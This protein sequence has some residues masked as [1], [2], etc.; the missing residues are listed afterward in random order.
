MSGQ[1]Y[2]DVYLVLVTFLTIFAVSQYNFN[3][4]SNINRTIVS[5][6]LFALAITVVLVLIIGF[7]PLHIAFIDMLNYNA[8]YNHLFGADFEFSFDVDNL[9]FD[10]WFAYMASAG[11][12]IQFFFLICAFVYF[13]S[14]YVA[15]AKL[16][17]RDTLLAL[18]VYLAAFSTFSY[19]TNGIKAGMAAAL[20]LVALAYS[21]KKL[22]SAL[23]A[24]ITLGI[25]HSMLLVIVAYFIV[26]LIRNP[27]WYFVLWCIA[28][29][30]AALHITYF[31]FLFAG[32]TDEHGA[33]YLLS[34]ENS[35]FR[36]DFI[37]YSAVP[38]I[39]G[40]VL[41]YKYRIKSNTYNL[42]LSVYMLSNSVWM[43]CM[44]SNFTNR[45]SYLS[46][47][48]YPFVLLYPFVNILWSR[49]QLRYLNYVVYGHI[50]FTIFM[51]VIYYKFLH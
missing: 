45:I 20:F 49:Y 18:V 39:L 7:R 41:L 28:F 51:Q 1:Y 46:W 19:G 35:G 44:Y 38:V 2:Y 25:H 22:L 17:P 23:I 50:G 11:V 10:N 13:G 15:S 9:L 33:E 12:P 36:I 48:M 21:D 8:V 30:F 26:L 4:L 16:F 27:K 37:I 14:I 3:I 42:L 34:N 5:K 6:R 24:L 31:Q 29:V 43:L 40:Y 32:F 47:F